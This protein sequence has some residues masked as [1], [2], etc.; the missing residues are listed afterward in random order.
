MEVRVQFSF[1]TI[2]IFDLFDLNGYIVKFHTSKL[3]AIVVNAMEKAT[4][5]GL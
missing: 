4:L 1:V 5:I 2:S 3:H